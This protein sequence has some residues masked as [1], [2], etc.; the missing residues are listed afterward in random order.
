MSDEGSGTGVADDR[1]SAGELSIA[2]TVSAAFEVLGRQ[3]VALVVLTLMF[4][5][6]PILVFWQVYG[7]PPSRMG[8]LPTVRRLPYL[9]IGF[10]AQTL[11]LAATTRVVLA[12]R[13]R[14]AALGPV[15]ALAISLPV[16]AGLFVANVFLSAPGAAMDAVE[17]IG[18]L[19]EMLYLGAS[20]AELLVYALMDALFGSTASVAVQERSGGFAA[21][22][23]AWDL[24]RGHRRSLIIAF[25]SVSVGSFLAKWVFTEQVIRPLLY[26]LPGLSG[27]IGAAIASMVWLT[28]GAAVN[29]FHAAWLPCVYLSL[30]KASEGLEAEAEAEVFS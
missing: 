16:L 4:E 14:G 11:L 13:L 2:S 28:L 3:W 23:R 10:V 29:I 5:V 9:A 18:R 19:P 15:Q 25:L 26:S 7:L 6:V 22:R 17:S 12:D 8:E 21:L 27:P 30:R 24:A 1:L 20:V